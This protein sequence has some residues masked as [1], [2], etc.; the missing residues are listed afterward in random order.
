MEQQLNS[1]MSVENSDDMMPQRP[2]ISINFPYFHCFRFSRLLVTAHAE[3]PSKVIQVN[4]EEQ[5]QVKIMQIKD[6]NKSF[7]IHHMLQIVDEA[8]IN[9]E[10][11]TLGSQAVGLVIVLRPL[12]GPLKGNAEQLV[13]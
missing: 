8:K 7:Q 10:I 5:E 2:T 9:H 3:H 1:C 4:G 11:L 12:L 13:K 6:L